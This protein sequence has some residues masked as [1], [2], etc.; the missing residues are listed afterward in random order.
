MSITSLG[1]HISR[2]V[3]QQLSLFVQKIVARR[4]PHGSGAKSQCVGIYRG[5]LCVGRIV[6][7][8]E[9]EKLG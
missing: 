3:H 2:S 9:G 1:L 7:M 4:G 8:F 6:R 5:Q